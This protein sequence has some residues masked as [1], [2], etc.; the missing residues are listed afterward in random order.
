M[1][2]KEKLKEKNAYLENKKIALMRKQIK[3]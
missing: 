1:Q 3:F 2:R